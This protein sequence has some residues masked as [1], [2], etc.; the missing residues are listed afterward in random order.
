MEMRRRVHVEGDGV[1]EQIVDCDV[2]GPNVGGSD[3]KSKAKALPYM[4]SEP[5]PQQDI[6]IVASDAGAYSQQDTTALPRM[7]SVQ[8]EHRDHMDTYY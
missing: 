6:V 2:V 1:G 3:Y 4:D 5:P 8:S 7:D